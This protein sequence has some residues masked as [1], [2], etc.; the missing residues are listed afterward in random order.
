[1]SYTPSASEIKEYVLNYK[2]NSY[3]DDRE[4]VFTYYLAIELMFE[5]QKNAG[6]ALLALMIKDDKLRDWWDSKIS[7]AKEE[8]QEAYE[9]SRLYDVKMRAYEKLSPKERS[10]LSIKK[11]RKPTR[12]MEVQ[13]EK[14][15]EE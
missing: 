15:E 3:R 12:Y 10:I 4:M 11:P 7:T 13:V 5:M 9:K 8:I 2:V 6:P 1:M 14:T